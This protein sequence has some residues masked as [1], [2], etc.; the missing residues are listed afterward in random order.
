VIKCKS[1][2]MF[3]GS[4]HCSTSPPHT[5]GFSQCPRRTFHKGTSTEELQLY[6]GSTQLLSQYTNL[7]T[8]GR[9]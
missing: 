4:S 1:K 7:Y 5:K 8:R 6:T 3:Q 9:H 2:D